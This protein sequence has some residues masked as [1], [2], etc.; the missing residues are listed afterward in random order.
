MSTQNLPPAPTQDNPVKVSLEI[1]PDWLAAHNLEV[2]YYDEKRRG[3]VVRKKNPTTNPV[4]T[5]S[6]AL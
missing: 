4:P 2:L 1:A 3:F 5:T 6:E